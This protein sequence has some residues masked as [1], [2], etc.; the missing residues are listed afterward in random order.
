MPKLFKS[1]RSRDEDEELDLEFDLAN[2]E[3]DCF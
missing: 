1:L 2:P 3:N